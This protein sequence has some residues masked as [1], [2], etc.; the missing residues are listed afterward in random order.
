[1]PQSGK[2]ERQRE[3]AIEVETRSGN[4]KWKREEEKS[5]GAAAPRSPH[6]FGEGGNL[7]WYLTLRGHAWVIEDK[8]VS[9][10]LASRNAFCLKERNNRNLPG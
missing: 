8:A 9:M 4:E 10:F 2:Q 7:N 3:A 5:G 1:M 6:G